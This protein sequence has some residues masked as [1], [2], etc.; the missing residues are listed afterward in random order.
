MSSFPW[1]CPGGAHS[2]S[3][4][5]HRTRDSEIDEVTWPPREASQILIEHPEMRAKVYKQCIDVQRTG[6]GE[7]GIKPVASNLLIR[8]EDIV[9]KACPASRPS[10]W[11]RDLRP[12][13]DIAPIGVLLVLCPN[14][15]TLSCK[16]VV[17]HTDR[18]PAPFSASSFFGIPFSLDRIYPSSPLNPMTRY[19]N[20]LKLGGGQW[21]AGINALPN[22]RT[23][24]LALWPTSEAADRWDTQYP[25]ITKLGV[26]ASQVCMSDS[27]SSS[28]SY[29]NAV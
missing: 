22:L 2:C 23:L 4:Y 1:S 26:N 29:M 25:H 17:P 19:L 28:S 8:C 12:G 11:I 24:D 13:S 20:T 3:I 16:S 5:H 6:Q 7:N 14:I 10:S 9:R 15:S 18:C 27:R 21:V